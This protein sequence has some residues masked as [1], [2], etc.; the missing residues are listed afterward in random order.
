[1][2]LR[3][4]TQHVKEQNWFA[5]GLDFLIV[6]VGVFIGIQVANWNAARLQAESDRALLQRLQGDLETIEQGLVSVIER[7][8]MTVDSTTHILKA[9]RSGMAPQNDTQLKNDLC[10]STWIYTQPTLSTA[11][12]EMTENGALTRIQSP[13]L[14]Q[15]IA[16]YAQNHASYN[17]MFEETHGSMT[18]PTN[19][20][21]V[22]VQFAPDADLWYPGEP[23]CVESYD[24]D[25]LRAA[26][27]EI[28]LWLGGHFDMDA[29]AS[30]ELEEIREILTL[31]DG[32]GG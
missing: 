5:V 21:Y 8:R 28:Q 30:S 15:A 3:R 9:V 14:R 13:V 18:T 6:V 25:K 24:F 2:R 17:R 11:L 7:N 23:G 32:G 26:Q 12:E 19:M 10:Q 1:M 29:Y 27:G 16:D 31:L 20:F 4:F 22:A